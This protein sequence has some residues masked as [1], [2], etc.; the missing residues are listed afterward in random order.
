MK[1]RSGV[2]QGGIVHTT[3]RRSLEEVQWHGIAHPSASILYLK[4]AAAAAFSRSHYS[5]AVAATLCVF[6]PS[7]VLLL[8]T[9]PTRTLKCACCSAEPLECHPIL[10]SLHSSLTLA[11]FKALLFNTLNFTVKNMCGKFQTLA[12]RGIPVCELAFL[13]TL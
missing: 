4:V 3:L 2:S 8:L 10:A 6:K 9:P 7:G 12:F 11:V 1:K 13:L 5:Q